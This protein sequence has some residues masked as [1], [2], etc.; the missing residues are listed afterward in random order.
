MSA[1]IF[2]SLALFTVLARQA[3]SMEAAA[4][5]EPSDQ[6]CPQTK[7]GHRVDALP[8]FKQ[9]DKLPCMYASN[10][11]SSDKYN[12]FFYYWLFPRPDST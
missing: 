6:L 10:M 3:L 2:K 1:R 9:G 4:F 8:Y 12:N 5:P 11:K 7:N